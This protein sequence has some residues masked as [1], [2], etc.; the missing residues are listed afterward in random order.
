MSTTED[1]KEANV[2]ELGY[3]VLPSVPE[4]NVPQVVS[5]IVSIVEKSEAKTLDSENPFLQPLAY[6]MSKTIGA[7][8]YIV[9]EAYIGWVKFEARP[10]QIE[11][12]RTAIEKIEEILRSL[13]IKAP[14]E[15][16]FTLAEARAKMEAKENPVPEMPE[17]I[18]EPLKESIIL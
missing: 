18:G 5:K 13:L 10:D 1:H 15:T 3:L 12:I 11:T 4:E 9:N 17:I 14:R 6:A 8:K 16:V 2:Y 7:R